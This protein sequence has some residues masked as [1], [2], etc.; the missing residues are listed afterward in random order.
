MKRS[1]NTNNSM[2]D[3][4]EDLV[5]LERLDPYEGLLK[6]K[7]YHKKILKIVNSIS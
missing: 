4:Y 2:P 5:R 6:S 3:P 7:F 1:K